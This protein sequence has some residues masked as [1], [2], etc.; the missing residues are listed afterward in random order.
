MA[1][2]ARP[3]KSL[4][5]CHSRSTWAALFFL[6]TTKVNLQYG[7]CRTTHLS[8]STTVPS[9]YPIQQRAWLALFS[10]GLASA[11]SSPPT[12]SGGGEPASGGASE[13]GAPGQNVSAGANAAAGNSA[14]PAGTAGAPG[15]NSAGGAA[16]SASGGASGNAPAPGGAGGAQ[17]QS[18]PPE[19]EW[20]GNCVACSGGGDCAQC[21]CMKCAVVLRTCETTPGCS[22]IAACVRASACAGTA[23]YCG[24]SSLLECANGGGNGPCKAA[25]LAAPGGKP[26]TAADP[27]AGP[28]S[29]ALV[30]VNQCMQDPNGCGSSCK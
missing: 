15:A 17:C 1:M 3:P 22:D 19:A 27:S 5:A 18:D 11:C 29:D 7:S 6:P 13:S 30:A 12:Q 2:D 28:A 8:R 24:T 14:L 4:L 25:M 20:E 9:R 26:P 23:C 21:A 10:L 16:G